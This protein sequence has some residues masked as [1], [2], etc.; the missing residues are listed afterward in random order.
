MSTETALNPIFWMLL[1]LGLSM[2]SWFA[3]RVSRTGERILP[4]RAAR[5]R[6]G[7]WPRAI[8]RLFELLLAALV[9]SVCL[10]GDRLVRQFALPAPVWL[11]WAGVGLG[12]ASLDYLPGRT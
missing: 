8:E 1:V 12:I 2:R 4:D 11:R 9:L 10:Q 5:Q 7:F 6:E 3:F